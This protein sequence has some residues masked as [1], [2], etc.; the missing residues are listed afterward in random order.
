MYPPPS[1]AAPSCAAVAGPIHTVA[2]CDVGYGLSVTVRAAPG[3]WYVLS[4]DGDGVA[5]LEARCGGEPLFDHHAFAAVQPLAHGHQGVV[6]S[7][8]VGVADLHLEADRGAV[9]LAVDVPG[10]PW[11]TGGDHPGRG[12]EA[13]QVGTH[14][15]ALRRRGVPRG[16]R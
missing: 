16:I 8:R 1:R 13:G 2:G 12:A 10:L 4:G 14:L 6:N 3:Y 9:D 11:A 7:G 5:W 15:L